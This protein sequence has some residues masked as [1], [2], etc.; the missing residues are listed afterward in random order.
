[1]TNAQRTDSA[2]LVLRLALGGVLLA[3]GLLKIFVFT[4]PGAAGFFESVG[5]PG[6]TGGVLQYIN[7]YTSETHPERK[8]PAGFVERTREL[9]GKYGER[10]NPPASL[11]EL[12]ESGETYSDTPAEELVAG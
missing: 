10:F 11:V 2:A 3:H 8:G 9:A 7:G 5:F 6:W 1:M 4:L 12:A